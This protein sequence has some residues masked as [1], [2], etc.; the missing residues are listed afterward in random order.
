M[1]ENFGVR[2]TLEN[3]HWCMY[4]NAGIAKQLEPYLGSGNLGYTLDVKQAV[5]SGDSIEAYCGDMGNRLC[6]VHLCDTILKNGEIYTCLPNRGQ[7]DFRSLAECILKQN[8]KS[9]VTLEVYAP[10]YKDLDELKQS[11][12]CALQTL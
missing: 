11:Y 10:D 6:N 5:Q 7:V 9:S 12:Q 2:L 3:V 1:A 4:S 8:P